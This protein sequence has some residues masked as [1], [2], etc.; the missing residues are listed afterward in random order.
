MAEKPSTQKDIATQFLLT[1]HDTAV[2]E[3]WKDLEHSWEVF[4]FYITLITG[5]VGFIL[6]LLSL[7]LDKY[8]QTMII[9]IAS[10]IVFIIG[11]TVHMQLVGT[12]MQY[13]SVKKRLI[14]IRKR[15]SNTLALKSYFETLKD[16]NVDLVGPADYPGYSLQEQIRRAIKVAGI[17]TQLVLLNSLVGTIAVI[18]VGIVMGMLNTIHLILLGIGGFFVLVSFH[19]IIAKIRSTG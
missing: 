4:K 10:S 3:I 9:L 2:K 5:S 1:E 18:A 8:L 6:A 19:S 12:D 15:I 17:K 13:R 14:L 7:S 11:L 16:A